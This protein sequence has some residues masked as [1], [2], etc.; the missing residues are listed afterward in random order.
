M[1]TKGAN[2]RLTLPERMEKYIER[3]PESGCWIWIGST[4]N[5]GYGAIRINHKTYQAHRVMW[6]IRNGKI[7]EDMCALHRCDIPSCVNPYHLFLGTQRDN[8]HDTI[9]KK[10]R[11][12]AR[13]ERH[14][15]AILTEQQVLNIRKDSRI[16]SVI[17]RD[18]GVSKSAIKHVK[19]LET[20]K[21]VKEIA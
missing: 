1:K 14:G 20:W 12:D 2:G 8:V 15:R 21:H 5:K 18:Y 4:Q 16:H 3:I 6:E 13:G 7:P 19:S 10:R 9:N 11:N 17:G